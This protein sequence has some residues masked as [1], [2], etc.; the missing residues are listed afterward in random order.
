MSTTM[1]LYSPFYFILFPIQCAICICCIVPLVCHFPTQPFHIISFCGMVEVTD[2]QCSCCIS[3]ALYHSILWTCPC[4]CSCMPCQHLTFLNPTTPLA[5][6][7]IPSV[8]DTRMD[9][10][11]HFFPLPTPLPCWCLTL[12]PYQICHTPIAELAPLLD[13][14]P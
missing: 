14:F 11:M 2:R 6:V 1:W 10:P 7:Y 12:P 5:R 3:F 13:L 9:Y 4:G 8:C